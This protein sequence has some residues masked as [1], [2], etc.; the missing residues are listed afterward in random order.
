MKSYLTDRKQNVEFK[1]VVST[2][3]QNYYRSTTG[4]IFGPQLFKIYI[5]DISEAGKLFNFIIYADDTALNSTLNVLKFNEQ[6]SE[7][8]NTVLSK[9]NDWL[10]A[11]KLP[12]NATKTKLMIFHKP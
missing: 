11:N 4:F 6:F 5:N 2:K 8:I 12:F 7:K 10:R 1:N 3:I 9:I